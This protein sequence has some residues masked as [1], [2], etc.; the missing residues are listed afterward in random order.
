MKL[1]TPSIPFF[2]FQ[3]NTVHAAFDG[4]FSGSYTEE[5]VSDSHIMGQAFG[6]VDSFWLPGNQIQ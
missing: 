5:N 6:E 2:R 3:G 1:Y 4:S